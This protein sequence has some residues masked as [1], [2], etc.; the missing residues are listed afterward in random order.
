MLGEKLNI[1]QKCSRLLLSAIAAS[2]GVTIYGAVLQTIILS[3]GLPVPISVTSQNH[4]KPELVFQTNLIRQGVIISWSG[5]S[6]D[7]KFFAYAE[8]VHISVWEVESGKLLHRFSG[9]PNEKYHNSWSVAFSPDSKLLASGSDGYMLRVWDIESGEELKSF[10]GKAEHISSVAFSSDGKLLATGGDDKSIRLWDVGSGR[11]IKSF[12]GHDR[13]VRLIVFSPDGKRLA[14]TTHYNSIKLWDIES[15]KLLKSFDVDY[16]VGSMD[17]LLKGKVL[18]IRKY[19]STFSFLD[20]ETGQEMKY[21][22][23]ITGD[24][25]NIVF[26]PDGQIMAGII[27]FGKVIRL[28]DI[29]SGKELQSFEP[30]VSNLS[31]AI[32]FSPD[33][34]V[35]AIKNDQTIKFRDVKSGKLLKSIIL[36]SKTSNDFVPLWK[37]LRDGKIL[38]FSWSGKATIH[39]WDYKS[40]EESKSILKKK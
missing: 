33:S 36:K 28:W 6:P 25:R 16:Y 19:Y 35:L 23:D 11:E 17:F 21:L 38:G 4:S 8:D 40:G 34:K 18:V 3:Q 37:F 39:R 31:T 14:S 1:P 29:E 27:L 5:F 24:I 7:G 32:I 26:S 9:K 20:I 10:E 2:L 15:G 22:N 12:A 13:T 30:D